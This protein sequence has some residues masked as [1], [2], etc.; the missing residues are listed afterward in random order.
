[1]APPR[2]LI[3][4][5]AG[6]GIG[7]H[8]AAQFAL[9]TPISHIILLARNTSRLS[10]SDAPF[11]TSHNASIKVSTLAIDLSDLSSI[12]GVL[13]QL[14]SMTTGEDVEVILFNAARIRAASP[15]DFS[16]EE[17]EEDLKVCYALV[18][19]ITSEVA[20]TDYRKTDN[21][22]SPLPG[23]STLHP[24]SPGSR[25]QVI[26]QTRVAGNQQSPPLGPCP[27]TSLPQPR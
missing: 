21:N 22:A 26:R 14:D 2:T 19:T 11:V 16:V 8:I 15:L 1:M 13:K 6:P 18:S 3:V 10:T 20:G 12:P 27:P 25:L 24:A 7:D 9:A 5:G 23:I 4:F 17:I